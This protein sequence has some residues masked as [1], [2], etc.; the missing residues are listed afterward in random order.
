[1]PGSF[2]KTVDKSYNMDYIESMSIRDRRDFIKRLV[3]RNNPQ[4]SKFFVNSNLLK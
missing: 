1:M 4:S 2:S 3:N